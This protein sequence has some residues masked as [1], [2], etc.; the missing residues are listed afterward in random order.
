M[1]PLSDLP[2]RVLRV[3]AQRLGISNRAKLRKTEL[4]DVIAQSGTGRVT[5]AVSE[6][7]SEEITEKQEL[8]ALQPKPQ[9][10]NQSTNL[11]QASSSKPTEATAP[12]IG[13][14]GHPG[15]PVPQSYGRD[16]LTLMV[17][18]PHHLHA[19]WEILPATLAKARAELGEDGLPVLIV[20]SRFG[21]ELRII[22]LKAGSYY[23]CVSADTTY[24]AD[25]GLRGHNGRV[26]IIAQSQTVHSPSDQISSRS[27]EQ[28]MGVDTRFHEFL[29][30]AGLDKGTLSSAD[31]ASQR[32]E[33][34]ERVLS[35]QDLFNLPSSASVPPGALYSSLDLLSSKN[36]S[37]DSLPKNQ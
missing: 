9:F 26:V 1:L 25:L 24:R 16:H 3:V 35:R 37:S 34:K 22:D 10:P 20:H 7:L 15:L 21:A 28:W 29:H 23:L 6:T 36:L 4:V 2:L 17:Q 30:M 31:L 12:A 11:E 5:K 14:H 19:Y 33:W 18:D 8:S 13:P 27:D 32:G